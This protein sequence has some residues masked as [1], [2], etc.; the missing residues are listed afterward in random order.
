MPPV[1]IFLDTSSMPRYL[2]RPG[3]DFQQIVEL[4]QANLA[5]VHIS[6]VAI[7]EWR[8]QMTAALR[9]VVDALHKSLRAT[10]RQSRAKDLT[11]HGLISQLAAAQDTT[12]ADAGRLASE[13][14]DRIL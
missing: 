2:A 14:C 5:E 1:V 13:D 8:A 7:R 11:H 6:T 10:L 9:E 3:H 4:V 12:A